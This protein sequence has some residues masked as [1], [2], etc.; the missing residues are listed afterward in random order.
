MKPWKP[1]AGLL[2]VF[3]LSSCGDKQ[4]SVGDRPDTE[5]EIPSAK[6]VTLLSWDEYFDPEILLKF[7][8]ETGI[9]VNYATFEEL[10]ELEA[11]LTSEP[12]K[13]DVIVADGTSLE[14]FV[15]LR[16]VGELDSSRIPNLKNIDPSYL[17]QAFDRGNRY[18][19]PYTWGTTLVAYR[20]DKIEDP[21]DSWQILWN[22][23]Y[24]GKVMVLGDR[25][26]ALGIGLITRGHGINSADAEHL[27]AAADAIIEQIDL[28]DVRFGSD[29][30]TKDAIDSGEA[31]AAVCYSGDAGVVAAENENVGF[32]IPKEG[33]PLW[34]DNFIIASD[35]QRTAEAHTLINFMLRADVAAAN[36]NF[37]WYATPNAAAAELVSEELRD[38][39][40]INPP[41][42]VRR[43]CYFFAKPDSRREELLNAA[44]ARVQ[45]ALRD[46]GK[47]ALGEGGLGEE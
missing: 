42:E 18:S 10:D 14:R 9:T 11:K 39:E 2:T 45:S 32:F 22:P 3:C 19:M 37:T 34:M 38:D 8:D 24:R 29:V 17:D 35:S 46:R 7:S 28:V 30:E 33:A 36:A 13:Y 40:T 16:L 44:W 25:T 43:R 26:E 1:I 15:E 41:E 27:N 31:W 12:G 20:A 4:E 23:E 5:N 6:V 47:I 21:G